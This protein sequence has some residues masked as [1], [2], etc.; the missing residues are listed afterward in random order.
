ME[1]VKTRDVKT[2]KRSTEGSAG[3]DFFIPD[4]FGTNIILKPGQDVKIASGIHAKIPTNYA[5]IMMNR[6]SV[7]ANKNLQ[8]G[9]CVIDEDYQGEIF[10]HLRNIGLDRQRLTPGEKVAQ[11]VLIPVNKA[12]IKVKSELSQLYDSKTKR[13]DGAFGSSGE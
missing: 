11:G 10:L 8:V 6:S 4:D 1:I 12:L 3:I 7:A 13:N 9:A 2:P 5:L